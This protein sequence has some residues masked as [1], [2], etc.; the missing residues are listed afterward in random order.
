MTILHILIAARW[1]HFA[2]LFALFGGPLSFMLARSAAPAEAARL[3][4]PTDLLLRI[5]A[6]TVAVSGLV[7]IAALIANMTGGFAEAATPDTLDAFFFETQFGPI[8]IIRLILLAAGVLA[9]ALPRGIRFGAWLVVSAG[10]IIDQAWL[11]HAANGGASLFGAAMV[12]I[13]A[14]HILAGAAWVGGLPILLLA[15]AQR[16]PAN[17]PRGIVTILSRYSALA[18][19]AV[20]LIIA[21]GIANA[22]FRVHGHFARLVATSYGEILLIKLLLVAVM[23]ALATYNR[24]IALPRLET[25]KQTPN[26]SGLS[27]SISVE[28]AFGVLVIGAAAL[29]GVTPPPA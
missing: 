10:L 9:I 1:V 17:G 5:A 15:L 3:F 12:S 6:V 18:T 13:Y 26:F 28:L 24:F 4:R 19:G 14:I 25:A 20:T 22:L 2:A 23:L 21:S 29:L 8:V 7:W 16:D 11:G 27:L